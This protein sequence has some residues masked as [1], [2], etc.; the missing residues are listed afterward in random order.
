MRKCDA[1]VFTQFRHFRQ[2]FAIESFGQ[3]AGRKYPRSAQVL[4]AVAQHLDQARLI[5]HGIGIGRTH[6]AGDAAGYRGL[7]LGSQRVLEFAARLAQARAQIDQARRHH[8]AVGGDGQ[9]GIESDG[10]SRTDCDD[11]FTV[12]EYGGDPVEFAGRIDHAAP[13][14]RGF[15]GPGFPATMLMTAMRTAMP[16]VTCG[17]ITAWPPSATAESISTPRFM[18]PGCITIASGLARASFSGV[19]P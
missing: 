3:G 7:H 15:H 10:R 1:T 13:N 8:E 6:K 4:G 9:V 5:E 16:K 14:D 19:R 2:A 12:D 17:R 18:G 11:A